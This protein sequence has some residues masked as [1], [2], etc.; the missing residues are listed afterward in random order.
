[1]QSGI[2]AIQQGYSCIGKRQRYGLRV[3]RQGRTRIVLIH[4][5]GG[6]DATC[7]YGAETARGFI[8]YEFLIAS[9][10]Q[11]T[12]AHLLESAIPMSRMAERGEAS[13]SEAR[14]SRARAWERI[15]IMDWIRARTGMAFPLAARAG[16]DIITVAVYPNRR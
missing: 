4:V 11:L 7:E 3:R 2:G 10:A 6:L 8:R 12:S 14:T 16:L 5:A 15:P 13:L 9:H 1:M